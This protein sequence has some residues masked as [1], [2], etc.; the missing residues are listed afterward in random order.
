MY[1][2]ACGGAWDGSA[3]SH[4]GNALT[5]QV[6]HQ[7]LPFRAVWLEADIDRVAMVITPTR[8]QV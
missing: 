2:R 8:V 3:K 1:V 6:I 5:A 7:R 4:E